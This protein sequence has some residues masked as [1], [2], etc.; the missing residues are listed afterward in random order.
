MSKTLYICGN[1]FD[2]HHGIASSYEKYREYLIKNK[3]ELLEWFDE[4]GYLNNDNLWKDVEGNLDIDFEEAFVS[5]YED[6]VPHEL[7]D[8]DSKYDASKIAVENEISYIRAFTTTEFL[9]WVRSINVS[10]VAAD[11]DLKFDEDSVFVNFNYTN[12]LQVLYGINDSSVLHIHGAI[13]KAVHLNDENAMH[14][15]IQFGNDKIEKH[16]TVDKYVNLH[17][18]DDMYPVL[19]QGGAEE[20]AKIAK[21]FSKNPR[22]NYPKLRDFLERN[23]EIENV[24]IMGHCLA[25]IDEAYYRDVLIPLFRACNWVAMCFSDQDFE[26]VDNFNRKYGMSVATKKW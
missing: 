5:A 3:P 22:R 11:K 16:E 10:D 23:K 24:V 25:G 21:L 20:I 19:A 18:Q 8:G 26:N 6:Y 12:T 9:N 1:G 14:D 13:N 7:A 15:S 2:L 17:G 4:Q